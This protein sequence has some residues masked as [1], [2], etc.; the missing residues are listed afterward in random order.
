MTSSTRTLIVSEIFHPEDLG[1]QGRQ[2]Y[3]LAEA[4][5]TC[6]EEIQV[7][8]RR[9]YSTSARHELVG[10]VPVHRLPPL[11]LTKGGGWRAVWPTLVFLGALFWTLLRLSRSYDVL[12]VHGVKAVLLPPLLVGLLLSKRVIVKVDATAE[13]EQDLTAESLAQ[14]GL[15]AQSPM[16]R[17]WSEVRQ[18]ML[19]G[20][21]GI[22]AISGDVRDVL[23]R[24]GVAHE[25]VHELPNGI[26]VSRWQP[27]ATG[28]KEALRTTLGL[29]SGPLFCYVGR[30]S[31][32]KGVL[33]L[34]QTWTR[35][36]AQHPEAHLLLIGSGVGSYDA[37]EDEIHRLLAQSPHATQVLLT[38][39]VSN[40]M[41]YLQASDAFV[42]CS[43]SEGFGLA[44]IEAMACGLPC[45]STPV[46]VAR[47]LIH[48]GENGVLVPVADA[49]S[50]A[51][52]LHGLLEQ[53]AKRAALGEAA[54]TAVTAR[55][56]MGHIASRYVQVLHQVVRTPGL[57]GSLPAR[58]R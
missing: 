3:D 26:D 8:T 27:P 11:G 56:D 44:L 46:G 1:G 5:L 10:R 14:M 48:S 54:H 20:A 19:K 25:K 30:L 41:D 28:Q 55:F 38:G 4:L 50:L 7:V 32:A 34:L 2:A 35:V 49:Q 24:M 45:I 36:C 22:V 43:H 39:Q 47:D 15:S 37:C 16:V 21:D 51:A 23:L 13:L 12:I 58:V 17:L 29:P 33:D 57:P 6:G 52:A 53:P 40:A 18:R 42:L 9:H 31:R